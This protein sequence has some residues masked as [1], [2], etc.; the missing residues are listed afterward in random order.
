[1]LLT[2]GALINR[3]REKK[4]GKKNLHNQMEPRPNAFPR[5]KSSIIQKNGEKRSACRLVSEVWNE[6]KAMISLFQNPPGNARRDLDIEK[7]RK[8]FLS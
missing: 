2:R 3:E 7:S 6:R 5:E 4:E 1:L 8:K